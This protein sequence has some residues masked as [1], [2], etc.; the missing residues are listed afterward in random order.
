VDGKGNPMTIR[1]LVKEMRASEIFGRAFNGSGQ[2]GSGTQPAN[3]GGGIPQ[4]RTKADLYKNID[5]K[6][7]RAMDQARQT[8]VQANGPDA[9]IALPD[10]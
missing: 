2:S 6:N 7:K 5:P 1:D 3:G 9:Y 10:R 8:Y 4:I